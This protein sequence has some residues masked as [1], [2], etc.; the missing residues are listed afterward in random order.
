MSYRNVDNI[1]IEDARIFWKNFS[2]TESR[3]NRAG[4]RNFCVAIPDRKLVDQL[5]ADG[6][7]VKVPEPNDD[8]S[9][10]DPY[11]QVSVAYNQYPP[12]IWMLAGTNKTL[13]DEESVSSLDYADIKSVDLVI[14]PYCWEISDK[15]G[16]K[17]GIKA[18]L[19]NMYVVIQEDKFA[20]KYD[21]GQT[22]SDG[23]DIPWKSGDTF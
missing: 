8:G 10:R 2:G 14:R 21:F 15:T 13:L 17:T 5:I 22:P 16:T 3:Y 12:K 6:W 1:N 20:A 23:D 4:N 19:K 11:I 18:Y 7:N 9:E